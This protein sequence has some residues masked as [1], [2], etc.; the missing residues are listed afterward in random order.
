MP[1]DT[2]TGVDL[3]IMIGH[4][5]AGMIFYL[6]MRFSVANP[7]F[8]PLVEISFLATMTFSL[9]RFGYLMGTTGPGV[10]AVF[11]YFVYLFMAACPSVFFASGLW[12]QGDVSETYRDV[13][14]RANI[15]IIISLILLELVIFKHKNR[16]LINIRSMECFVVRGDTYKKELMLLAGALIITLMLFA[17]LRQGMFFRRVGFA[18]LD[19]GGGKAIALLLQAGL[20]P[21][22]GIFLIVA[23]A[24]S[25]ARTK[26]IFN[27]V[28]IASVLLLLLSHFPVGIARF[29]M[30]FVYSCF[31]YMVCQ[32]FRVRWVY[33]FLV[34]WAGLA[35]SI[36]THQFRYAGT[37]A[38]FSFENIFNWQYFF[39]GHFD[40]YENFMYAVDFVLETGAVWGWQLVGVVLFFF[41]RVFWPDKPIST[42]AYLWENYYYRFSEHTNS[43][44]AAPI[45]AEFYIN[46]GF[47]GVILMV[48]A[49]YLLYK[50]FD[51]FLSAAYDNGVKNP[52]LY[53]AEILLRGVAMFFL[54]F[55]R[56]SLQTA[57]AFFT[58]IM[59]SILIVA[60][61]I[62]GPRGISDFVSRL[63]LAKK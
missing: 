19:L 2:F 22:C 44:L 62:N 29:Y 34:F 55:W 33:G 59:V 18:A 49:I 26:T 56:G 9:A 32:F 6:G 16:D 10:L 20:R 37:A 61:I 40:A 42:G 21:L 47:I 41:P 27:A 23:A 14:L 25:Y 35:F 57:F 58:S 43:Q 7:N 3:K 60:F 15:F 50:R 63:V 12:L 28:F 24:L 36:L 53:H 5:L 30:L 51:P 38:V 48:W 31:L 17:V 54:F 45:F 52:S 46:F 13:I 11:Y 39:D 1:S 4:I 8:D